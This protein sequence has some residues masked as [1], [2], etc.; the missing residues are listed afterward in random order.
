M[1]KDD[2][3]KLFG[4][5]KKDIQP[6]TPVVAFSETFHDNEVSLV[7]NGKKI[8]FVAYYLDKI[9]VKGQLRVGN[10]IVSYQHANMIVNQGDAT[11]TDII[12]LARTMQDS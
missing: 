8:I 3:L 5:V 11:S 6:K 9:G 7:S 10:A 2:T 1:P 12:N 4:T